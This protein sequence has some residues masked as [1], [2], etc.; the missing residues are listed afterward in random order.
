MVGA[1]SLPVL[2]SASHQNVNP[3]E[4]IE[5]FTILLTF[6]HFSARGSSMHQLLSP[7]VKLIY[8]NSLT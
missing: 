5:V 4:T 1:V 7:G 6:I 3:G 2:A 8:Q